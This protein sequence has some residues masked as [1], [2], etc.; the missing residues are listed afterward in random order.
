MGV[1][2]RKLDHLVVVSEEGSFTRAAARLHLSQQALSTSIRSLEREVGVPLLRRDSSGVSALPAG[3]A[4]I[5]DARILHGVARAALY[6]ARRIGR[7]ESETLCIGHTP[8][9]TGEEIAALLR[10][11]VPDHALPHTDVHQRYPAQLIEE[12]LS[13]DLDLGLCRG[14]RPPRGLTRTTLTQH[15]LAIAVAADHHLADRDHVELSELADEHLMVWGQPGNSGYTDLLFDH[16]RR[17]GFEPRYTRNPIQGTPPVTAV[18]GTGHFAFVTTPPGP[19]AG[20]QARVVELRPPT[21]APLHALWSPHTTNETRDAV[22]AA[23]DH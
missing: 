18:I 16:C 7:G 11:T 14:I 13:G 2:L 4:L 19:A 22:L 17:A 9:V 1:D 10:A 15:R 3:Q 5:D 6:R 20:G 8:A 21:H 23:N 12:L